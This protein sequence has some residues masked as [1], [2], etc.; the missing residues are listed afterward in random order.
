M[1]C[2]SEH[3]SVIL[4][5]ALGWLRDAFRVDFDVFDIRISGPLQVSA[6]QPNR[7][8]GF[9]SPLCGTVSRIGSFE[10][11]AFEGGL[12]TAAFP[13]GRNQNHDLVALGTF[14]VEPGDGARQ[15]PPDTARRL[16]LELHGLDAWA[17]GAPVWHLPTLERMCKLVMAA[18]AEH[19]RANI[20]EARILALGE[21]LGTSNEEEISLFRYV[22][23]DMRHFRLSQEV[24][25][26]ARFVVEWAQHVVSAD[27]GLVQ[28]FDKPTREDPSDLVTR[29]FTIGE[30]PIPEHRFD[31]LLRDLNLYASRT[32][33]IV[34]IGE[35]HLDGTSQPSI[36]QMIFAPLFDG[37]TYLGRLALFS[38]QADRKF[39]HRDADLLS[40]VTAMLTLHL[41]NAMLYQDQAET[42]TGLV[43]ALSSVIEAKDPYTCG[44]SDRVAIMS[45]RL[46]KELGYE[47]NI[48]ADIY[49]GG[50]LHDIGK[51]GIQDTV[52]RK[53]GNLTPSEFE[54]IRTHALV[55]YSILEGLKQLDSIRP[56]VLHHHESWDGNGYPRGLRG[57]DIPLLARIVAVADAYDA[58]S[59]DRPY[60]RRMQ[61]ESIREIFRKGAGKQWD[62]KVIGAIFRCWDDI[63]RISFSFGNPY[64][65]STS[66]STSPVSSNLAI[67]N[68]EDELCPSTVL[69]P[70]F[71]MDR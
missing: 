28:L 38:H 8:W 57:E 33:E 17:A 56:I 43:R 10:F 55:G 25:E 71:E 27:S 34:N 42:L 4:Q 58:M 70:E 24:E 45:R 54:H 29:F 62:P 21:I 11:I 16:G 39:G 9:H 22:C 31:R 35:E 15:L 52:L 40:S 1:S 61:R 5:N 69:L 59:S 60:R 51:I 65:I 7:D 32:L 49:L 19:R 64:P 63:E 46:A 36:H 2:I 26:M 30:C 23:H 18:I 53:P 3:S 12:I 66:G 14:L 48:L 6:D 50:L 41:A 37:E 47:A 44:H 67:R 20:L 68:S 13:L